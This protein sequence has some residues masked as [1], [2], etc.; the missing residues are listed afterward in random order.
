MVLVNSN[1]A[2]I[3]TDP[4]LS[5]RTYIEPISVAGVRKVLELEQERGTPI[6]AL[7]PTLGGQTALNCACQLHDEGV[8]TEFNVEMIAP[9]ARSS[10][11]LKIDKPS[12]KSSK[13]WA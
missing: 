2:T 1:P 10:T 6:D 12:G 7:L 11:G 13:S 5:D 8:L 9:I 4:G 3:M